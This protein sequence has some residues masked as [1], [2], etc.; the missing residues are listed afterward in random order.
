V[1]AVEPNFYLHTAPAAVDRLATL[2]AEDL[3][4]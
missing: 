4:A 1:E 2:I 3:A